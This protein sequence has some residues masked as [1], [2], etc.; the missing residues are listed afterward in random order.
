MFHALQ[1][2]YRSFGGDYA[3]VTQLIEPGEIADY[4]AYIRSWSLENL[5]EGSQILG[6]VVGWAPRP[7]PQMVERRLVS[8]VRLTTTKCS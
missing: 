8:F 2:Q 3:T 5:P 4:A 7:T 6:A 1:I